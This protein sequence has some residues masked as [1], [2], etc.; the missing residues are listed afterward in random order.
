VIRTVIVDDEPPARR[1][2]RALLADHPDV[3][4]IA[5]CGTVAQAADAIATDEP[6]LVFLD[7]ALQEGSGFDVLAQA[8]DPPAVVFITA[9]SEHA[10]RAFDVAAVDYLLKPYGRERLAQALERV[11]AS[12]PRVADATRPKRLAVDVGRRIRLVEAA[13][14]DYLRVEGNYV[15]LYAGPATYL[16]R[17]T[18]TGVVGQ[19]DPGA[20]VR[21]HRS[22]AVR[23]DR[24]MEV[25]ILPH[26]EL[27]LTLRTGTVLVSGRRFREQVRLAL[28]L[29]SRP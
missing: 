28:G 3:A 6:D 24:V 4:V 5:E 10:T 17:D 18:L 19:L 27:A 20:F 21:I 14:I 13:D 8:A 16:V 1:R 22:L 15:R 11:R 12:L 25:Q 26:G 2:L 9:Y 7:V 29:P 23:L